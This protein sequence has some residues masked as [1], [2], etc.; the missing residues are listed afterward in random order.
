MPRRIATIK[1]RMVKLLVSRT[2]GTVALPCQYES[3][4]LTP[5][6]SMTAGFRNVSELT[7][8]LIDLTDPSVKRT[9]T[10]EGCEPPN[11]LR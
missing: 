5:W 4:S 7:V 11:M 9:L 8:N 2:L 6:A 3:A 1:S 10:P